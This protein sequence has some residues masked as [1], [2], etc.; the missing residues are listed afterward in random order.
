MEN[1]PLSM[2]SPPWQEELSLFGSQQT[3]DGVQV[4]L[5]DGVVPLRGACWIPDTS[6]WP[7][8]D[9]AFLPVSLSEIL[10][11]IGPAEPYWLSPKACAGILRRATRRGKHLPEALERPLASPA[12]QEPLGQSQAGAWMT[13]TA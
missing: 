10:Q 3:N 5:L 8:G 7:S 13:W 6:E 2:W 9:D 11:R 12:V 4:W 1:A